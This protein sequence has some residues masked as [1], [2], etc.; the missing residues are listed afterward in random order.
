MNDHK[1]SDPIPQEEAYRI[2]EAIR[3]EN[4]RKPYRIVSGLWC[5]GCLTFTRD[6]SERCGAV[7][8]CP[9]VVTYHRKTTSRSLSH[10]ASRR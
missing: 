7:I 6:E 10:L 3:Q 4:R 2:C 1:A 8:G 5:W 9:Q